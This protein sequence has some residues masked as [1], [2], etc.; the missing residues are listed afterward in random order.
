MDDEAFEETSC[1]TLLQNTWRGETGTVVGKWHLLSYVQSSPRNMRMSICHCSSQYLSR[2]TYW[3]EWIKVPKLSAHTLASADQ[4]NMLWCQLKIFPFGFTGECYITS[5]T[6]THIS[7]KTIQE[8]KLLGYHNPSSQTL[9]ITREGIR[10]FT[11]SFVL[12]PNYTSIG[13]TRLYK[14]GKGEFCCQRW[15]WDWKE[16]RERIMLL[17][18]HPKYALTTRLARIQHFPWNTKIL[19]FYLFCTWVC[20]I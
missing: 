6:L 13:I 20:W 19:K 11:R 1:V 18:L 9:N 10:W 17:I 16:G 5:Y 3:G 4:T 14:D 8:P 2:E 15:V 12:F 7:V